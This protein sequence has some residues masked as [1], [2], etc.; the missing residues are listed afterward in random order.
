MIGTLGALPNIAQLLRPSDAPDASQDA[1]E[2]RSET[3][4][5]ALESRG[6]GR[7]GA[8]PFDLVPRPVQAPGG[9]ERGH[10]SDHPRYGGLTQVSPGELSQLRAERFEQ[11]VEHSLSFEVTTREG[12]RVT[13]QFEQLDYAG[14]AAN[15]TRFESA[16]ASQRAVSMSV[17]GDLSESELAAIDRAVQS[18][19]ELASRFFGGDLSTPAEVLASLDFD[20]AELSTFALDMRQAQSLELTQVYQPAQSRLSGLASRNTGI[21]DLLQALGDGQRRMIEALGEVLDAPSAASLTR[22]LVPEL[23][24]PVRF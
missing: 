18:A 8:L 4:L 19:S 22:G 2:S 11:S 6:L 12:D 10:G 21:A 17:V 5:P 15:T 7:F 3:A 1:P 9:A 23:I 14:Y 24:A 13:L 16:Q 20:S